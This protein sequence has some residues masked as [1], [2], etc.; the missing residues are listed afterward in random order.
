M[1]LKTGILLLI[2]S[3]YCTEIIISP[4]GEAIQRDSSSCLSVASSI[5]KS[6]D[7]YYEK[8]GLQKAIN[9]CTSGGSE[10]CL[11]DALKVFNENSKR[12]N[13]GKAENC[14]FI[15][16]KKKIVCLYI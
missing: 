6:A 3:I 16:I 5:Y 2:I 7:S 8:K 1:I 11:L 13:I 10:K 9:Y 14:K 12:A 4:N 15:Y